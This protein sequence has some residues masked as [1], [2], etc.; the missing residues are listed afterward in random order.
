MAETVEPSKQELL[1]KIVHI[2]QNV[3]LIA[4]GL[5]S[6]AVLFFW[7][8]N[9]IVISR[10]REYNL[11]GIVHYTDEYVK[12]AGY[13][14]LQDVFTFFHDPVLIALSVAIVSMIVLFV[15]VGPFK[16]KSDVHFT[17]ELL[18]NPVK[19]VEW[20]KRANGHYV[21]FL[22]IA[23]VSTLALALDWGARNLARDIIADADTLQQI[24]RQMDEAAQNRKPAFF[25]FRQNQEKD[26]FRNRF[27]ADL[28]VDAKPT[29]TWVVQSIKSVGYGEKGVSDDRLI[30]AFQKD[31]GIEEQPDIVTAKERIEKSETYRMLKQ[32][33]MNERL[34]SKIYLTAKNVNTVFVSLLEGDLKTPDDYATLVQ[35]PGNYAYLNGLVDNLM[36][37]R[38]NVI[39]CFELRNDTARK[40]MGDIATLTRIRLGNKLITISFLTMVGILAYLLLNI[41]ELR[42]FEVAEKGYYFMMIAL[43]VT[44]SI[45]LPT[46]YGRYNF[47]FKIQRVSAIAFSNEEG[48]KDLKTKLQDNLEKQQAV[49]VLGPTRDKEIIVSTILKEKTAEAT[50]QIIVM[51]RAAIRY[52][53]LEPVKSFEIPAL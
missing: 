7:I 21:I 47:E 22:T 18:K 16:K 27:I 31:L 1:E 2:V 25:A 50:P 45:T 39:A 3:G 41:T 43:F 37:I 12:E 19:L 48:M 13:Q 24:I 14:F 52:I 6:L 4:G 44:I 30:A 40:I 5:G 46:V 49:Y 17:F 10:L 28:A 36:N 11:Y 23:F 35:N 38:K 20:V 29:S 32:I 33:S 34:N 51:D 53:I 42:K 9:V 8:G 26:T 15:P